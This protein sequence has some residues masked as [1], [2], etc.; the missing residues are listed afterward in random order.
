MS[1]TPPRATSACTSL[2]LPCLRPTQAPRPQREMN[3]DGSRPDARSWAVRGEGLTDAPSSSIPCHRSL[4]F[5]PNLRGKALRFSPAVSPL[6]LR[7]SLAF[8]CASR[9]DM[10]YRRRYESARKIEIGERCGVG[11]LRLFS[12]TRALC[13]ALQGAVARAPID[14]SH[15]PS[16]QRAR[17][18]AADAT[19]AL[20]FAPTLPA[21][22]AEMAFPLLAR[23]KLCL[24]S[25]A[26]IVVL[27]TGCGLTRAHDVV[28][29]APT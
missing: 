25:I 17:E 20:K 28:M 13:G 24:H 14:Y 26:K 5:H 18:D 10:A 3:R 22:L 6:P 19:D 11:P 2:S 29:L 21:L 16:S 12:L 15:V 4:R 9:P 23:A 7:P 27:R 8:G 1:A